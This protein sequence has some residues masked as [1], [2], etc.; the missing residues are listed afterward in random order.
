MYYSSITNK[1]QR[2]TTF[3]ITVHALHELELTHGSGSSKQDR[4]L[5]NIGCTVFELLVV[6]GETARNM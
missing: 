1:M 5:P 6:G 3:F 2:Y 4:H